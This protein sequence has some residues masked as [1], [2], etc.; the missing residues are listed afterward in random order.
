VMVAADY[1]MKRMGMG[2]EPA[3]VD[4]MPSFM[5]MI[6]ASG[7]KPASAMPRWWMEPDYEPLLRD[8]DGLAWEIPSATVKT[9][10]ENDFFDS[11]GVRHETGKSDALSQKWAANMTQRYDDLA[12]AE[13]VFAELQNC[14]DLAVVAALL[15]NKDLLARA[16]CDLPMLIGECETARLPAPKFVA[17]EAGV[18][19]IRRATL[20]ACGGV[21]VN[22][23]AVVDNNRQSDAV[24][25]V[26]E[27]L[28][29]A[30]DSSWWSN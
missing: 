6:R 2:F 20:I 4:G 7:R 24:A 5:H 13:P 14:M 22:P 10:T 29:I 27:K 23:W 9:L 30:D 26:R 25:A 3:P 21:K 19:K 18:M 15:V 11:S 28:A 1:R 16:E 8:A 17:S 12:K